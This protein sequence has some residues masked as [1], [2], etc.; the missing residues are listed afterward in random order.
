MGLAIIFTRLS[1]SFKL[2]KAS[3]IKLNQGDLLPWM[4]LSFALVNLPQGQWAQPTSLG[5]GIMIAGLLFASLN[6]GNRLETKN[7]RSLS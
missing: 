5:F 1:L 2:A 6:N 7:E 3:F 4:L